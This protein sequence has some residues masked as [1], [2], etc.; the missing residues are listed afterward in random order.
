MYTHSYYIEYR[1]KSS[2]TAVVI[3][4]VIMQYLLLKL[5]IIVHYY[6][7]WLNIM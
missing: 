4:M 7:V 1:L 5:V 6:N 2:K 3:N